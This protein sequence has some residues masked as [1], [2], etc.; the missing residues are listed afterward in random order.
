MMFWIG[1]LIG[2]GAT[3]AAEIVL[4]LLDVACD[5]WRARRRDTRISEGARRALLRRHRERFEDYWP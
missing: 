2:V 4:L 5:G 1:V 3:L